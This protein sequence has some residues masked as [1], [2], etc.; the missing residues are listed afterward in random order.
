MA[1]EKKVYFSLILCIL[2]VLDIALLHTCILGPD[3]WNSF[4][5]EY[6]QLSWHKEKGEASSRKWHGISSH[7]TGQSWSP[8]QAWITEALRGQRSPPSGIASSVLLP[9]GVASCWE[10]CWILPLLVC[11]ATTVICH[12]PSTCG[13]LGLSFLFHWPVCFHCW[14]LFLMEWPCHAHWALQLLR[15]YDKSLI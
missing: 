9:L 14:D 4:S 12:V 1:L 5:L 11:S 8:G 6:R 2:E 13:C 10:G 15:W 3:W 7:F